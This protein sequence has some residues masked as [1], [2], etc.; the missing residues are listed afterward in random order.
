MP[1]K[2]RFAQEPT[3]L[4][5]T[6]PRGERLV[7]ALHGSV[8]PCMAISC[9]GMFSDK[10]GQKHLALAA[11]LEE[12][13][14][15]LL[16][17]DFAGAGE[18]EGRLFDLSYTRRMEDL[19]SAINTLCQQGARF[20]AVFGSSLGGAVALL[21]AARDERIVGVATLA[22]M[23]HPAELLE[24]HP[25]AL[26]SWRERGYHDFPA[27]R[28]GPTFLEDSL[29]H[30]VVGAVSVLRA[31]VFVVHGDQDEVIPCSDAHDI[32]AAARR[33]SLELVLGADH[34]FSQAVHL[35]PVIGR[36]ATFLADSLRS[37]TL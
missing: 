15:P 23:G 36:I 35:R 19:D 27:G 8:Q 4:S 2:L 37:V 5:F 30:D 33:A 34:S 17:F 18:S 20:F 13:G 31:P 12:L 10:G 14:V 26:T 9:H 1:Q 3:A 28:V 6:N 21:T 22:A 24:S 7:G 16:R 32:A 29:S 11:A 25:Q